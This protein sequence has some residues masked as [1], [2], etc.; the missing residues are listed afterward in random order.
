MA[1]AISIAQAVLAQSHRIKAKPAIVTG[2][3]AIAQLL[4]VVASSLCTASKTRLGE[5]RL[6]RGTGFIRVCECGKWNG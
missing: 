4:P 1:V 6:N 5:F 3:I 2:A